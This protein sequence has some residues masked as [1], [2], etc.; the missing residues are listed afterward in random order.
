MLTTLVDE[1]TN[2]FRGVR[3]VTL[4]AINHIECARRIG[5]PL[6][7][8]QFC[9]AQPIDFKVQAPGSIIGTYRNIGDGNRYYLFGLMS[10][11]K[12][13]MVVYTYIQSYLDWIMDKVYYN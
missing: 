10:Y 5:K 4:N 1:T 12:D 11:S 3:N 13:G 9:V 8:N 6:K 2:D 7:S